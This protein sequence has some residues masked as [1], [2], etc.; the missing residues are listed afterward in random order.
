M[1]EIHYRSNVSTSNNTIELQN[2]IARVLK[3]H[4]IKIKHALK[5]SLQIYFIKGYV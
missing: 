2:E 4:Y 5:V 3:L 1:L